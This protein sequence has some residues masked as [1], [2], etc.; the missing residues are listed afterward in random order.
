MK[1]FT[2]IMV[3]LLTACNHSNNSDNNDTTEN[4]I[5][6]R[7]DVEGVDFTPE[8]IDSAYQQAVECVGSYHKDNLL[9]IVTDELPEYLDWLYAGDS[10]MY[11]L[12][13]N[14]DG[15]LALADQLYQGFVE[16]LVLKSAGEQEDY[17]VD[18]ILKVCNFHY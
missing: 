9:V 3:I 12:V 16:Y 14:I 11:I 1:I 2:I 13:V 18:I 6:F 15:D 4:G 5:N 7:I 10:D 8:M 17:L